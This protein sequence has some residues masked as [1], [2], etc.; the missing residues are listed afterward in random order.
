MD[1]ASRAS[2]SASHPTG[3][4]CVLVEMLMNISE[5]KPLCKGDTDG[6][7]LLKEVESKR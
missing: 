3:V 2:A 5:R 4:L 6:D 7:L 1:G